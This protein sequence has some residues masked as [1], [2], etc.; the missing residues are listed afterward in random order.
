MNVPD[1]YIH[2]YSSVCM[3]KYER[4]V[5]EGSNIIA[6]NECVCKHYDLM[7]VHVQCNT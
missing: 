7:H 4:S 2:M 6:L 5:G 3:H 1:N